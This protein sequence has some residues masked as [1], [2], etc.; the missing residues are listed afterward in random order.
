M[1]MRMHMHQ[2]S[3][4]DLSLQRDCAL[5]GA[6]PAVV[7]MA[8]CVLVTYVQHLWEGKEALQAR[9]GSQ[10]EVCASLLNVVRCALRTLLLWLCFL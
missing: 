6:P 2:H 7:V 3:C 10:R 4:I 9:D 8:G 1:R 5:L